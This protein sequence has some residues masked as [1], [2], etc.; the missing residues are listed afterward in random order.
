LLGIDLSDRLSDVRVP[1]LVLAGAA[2]RVVAPTESERI[3]RLVHGARLEV[4]GGAGHVLPLERTA[5]LADLILQ[6]VPSGEHATAS[7][8]TVSTPG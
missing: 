8:P 1:L 2:D 7:T 6:L 4:F 5:Q 3:A